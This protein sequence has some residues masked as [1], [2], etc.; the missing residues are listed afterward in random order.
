MHR[1]QLDHN[2]LLQQMTLFK[3]NEQRFSLRIQSRRVGP[4]FDS[5]PA[6]KVQTEI[7][8]FCDG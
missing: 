8:V 2:A 4:A 1:E 3:V 6:A 7:I 5:F